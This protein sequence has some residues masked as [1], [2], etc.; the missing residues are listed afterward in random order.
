[1]QRLL[2][3]S[4]PVFRIFGIDVRFHWMLPLL[5]IWMY[6]KTQEAG[7]PLT[8]TLLL[9][10]TQ[11]LSILIHELG[12]C[13]AARSCLLPVYEII[14]WPLGGLSM[15]GHSRNGREEIFVA[16]AGPIVG[17]LA[18]AL[19]IA[20][21]ALVEGRTPTWTTFDPF[22]WAPGTTILEAVVKINMILNLWNLLI[23]IYPLDGGRILCGCLSFF[24]GYSRAILLSTYIGFV[25]GAGMVVLGI[26]QL[27]GSLFLLFLGLFVIGQCWVTREAVRYGMAAEDDEGPSFEGEMETQ[28]VPTRRPGFWA[29]WKMRR[30]MRRR[31]KREQERRRIRENVDHLLERISQ[32]GLLGLSPAERKT[33]ERASRK[34]R[35]M[36]DL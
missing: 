8:F 14:L 35:E 30:E 27:P 5:W 13:F 16:A 22:T 33:L 12:H 6:V 24:F 19:A 1:M 36:E 23:P 28:F 34:L 26:L 25:M 3:W 15:V 31:R 4:F 29:R 20:A 9:I 7:F 21:I 11:F 10:L 2:N 18:Q 17:L 32:V